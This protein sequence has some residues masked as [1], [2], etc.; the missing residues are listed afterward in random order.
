MAVNARRRMGDEFGPKSEDEADAQWHEVERGKWI[1]YLP[2]DDLPES[3]V[4]HP[5]STPQNVS[6]GTE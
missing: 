5:D 4:F 6:Q 1:W 2:L 3:S